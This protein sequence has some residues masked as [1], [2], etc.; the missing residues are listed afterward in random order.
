MKAKAAIIGS[1]HIGTDLL[2]KILPTSNL[3]EAS[4]MVGIDPMSQGLAFAGRHGVTVVDNGVQD[5]LKRPLMND[6]AVIFDA[7]SAGAHRAN[8]DALK[9]V[10]ARII[11]LTP[12]AVGPFVVPPV[13]LA[14]SCGRTGR[15]YG[16][17]WRAG[18]HSDRGGSISGR[19]GPLCRNCGLDCVQIGGA[20]DAGKYRRIHPDHRTCHRKRWGASRGKAIIVLNPA[21]PPLMMRDTVVCL[22]AGADHA[23]IR[24]SVNNMIELVQ[25]Y[26]PGYRLKQNVQIEN[27]AAGQ[28]PGAPAGTRVTVFLEIEGAGHH[29]PVYAGNLDI[30]TSAAMR[31]AEYMVGQNN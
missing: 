25:G 2:V 28:W 8:L 17:M 24:A 18:N 29:L 7:T 20:R 14:G 10:R 5:L 30:M 13:N 23:A 21:E 31:A 11:D 1:G 15:E 22:C 16:D 12:A 19:A 26:V 9:H 3:L 6:I 27:V 4:V